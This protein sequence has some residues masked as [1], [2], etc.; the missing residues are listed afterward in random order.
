M[1]GRRRTGALAANSLIMPRQHHN[2]V[3]LLRALAIL[4]V[5]AHHA[6]HYTGLHIPYLGRLGGLLGVELFF[7]ISGYLIVQSAAQRSSGA[8]WINRAFRVYPA[9]WVAV[10][11]V[12]IWP[13]GI[14]LTA[15]GSDWPYFLVNLLSWSHFFPYAMGRFDVL[16]VSWTLAVEWTWYLLVPGLLWAARRLSLRGE[17]STRFWLAALLLGSF[18]SFAWTQLSYAGLFDAW[19]WPGL[20]KLGARSM[21]DGLRTAF[22]ASAAPAQWMFFLLGV[23]LWSSGRALA[24]VPALVLSILALVLLANPSAWSRWLGAWT[25]PVTAA[26]LAAFFALALRMPSSWVRGLVLRPLHWLGDL[27]Y[28]VYLVHVPA[29]FIVKDR[30]GLQGAAAGMAT[31]MLTLALAAAIHHLVENPARRLGAR[32]LREQERRPA[33]TETTVYP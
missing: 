3:N 22:I 16:A 15:Q 12:S 23:L 19:Y 14:H 26:G 31:V 8:F 4:A 7:L 20:Q 32:L 24:R 2:P 25:Y 10:L 29:I 33:V 6:Q 27:S 5:W 17:G 11:A 28:A 18:V 30:F 9:Y 13:S 1:H 21:T